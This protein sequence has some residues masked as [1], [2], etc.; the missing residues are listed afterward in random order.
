MTK[1]D[2]RTAKIEVR[3]TEQ[4]KENLRAYAQEKHLSMSEA[5]RWIC[6]DILNPIIER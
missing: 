5:I 3:L 6:E 2:T 1:K 4:E